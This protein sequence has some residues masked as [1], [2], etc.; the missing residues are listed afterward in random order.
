MMEQIPVLKIGPVL[1]VTIQIELHDRLAEVL[2][3]SI[4]ERI[5]Q[6]GTVLVDI[7]A[8]EMVDSFVGRVLRCAPLSRPRN[9]SNGKVDERQ[10]G[11][12][13]HAPRRNH[14]PAGNGAGTAGH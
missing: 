6:T 4:L 11:A 2:Q 3:S 9:R 5:H 12:G 1:M 10:G 14:D 8:L 13:G 7:S